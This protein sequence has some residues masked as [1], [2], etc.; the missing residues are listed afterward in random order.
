[1]LEELII[2]GT[3]ISK[4]AIKSFKASHPKV[5]VTTQP[6]PAGMINPFTA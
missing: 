6:P 5:K 2:V 1:M 3:K 4:E